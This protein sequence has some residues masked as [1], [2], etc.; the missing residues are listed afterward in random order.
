[1]QLPLQTGQNESSHLPAF[2][3]RSEPFY[4]CRNYPNA[5]SR[6]GECLGRIQ[7]LNGKFRGVIEIIEWADLLGDARLRNHAFVS[8]AGLRYKRYPQ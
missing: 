6:E 3:Y 7:E 2:N 8:A 4:Q 1:M 5:C